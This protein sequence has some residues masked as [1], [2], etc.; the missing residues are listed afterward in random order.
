MQSSRMR[1]ASYV[2]GCEMGSKS[3][4]EK[5]NN[6]DHFRNLDVDGKIIF[7]LTLDKSLWACGLNSSG[8]GEERVAV[9]N[10]NNN[11]NNNNYYYY[12]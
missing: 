7:K 2:E 11:N 6:T 12:Y 9:Y 4:Y 3:C 10:N 5:L 1:C 8:S